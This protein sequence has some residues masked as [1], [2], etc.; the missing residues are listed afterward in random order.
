[1]RAFF[2]SLHNLFPRAQVAN[3]K[4]FTISLPKSTAGVN[5][6]GMACLCWDVFPQTGP[7]RRLS[8]GAASSGVGS[9]RTD[10]MK[11]SREDGSPSE[12]PKEGD[13]S[14]V[15][16]NRKRGEAAGGAAGDV[17]TRCEPILF[18]RYSF[19]HLLRRNSNSK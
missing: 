16:A 5:I 18:T 3:D 9:R 19:V 17:E 4:H 1:M 2:S 7:A 6:I 13:A 15:A 10:P 8:V 12:G 14:P 11:R